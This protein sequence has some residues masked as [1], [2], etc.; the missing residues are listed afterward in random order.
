MLFFPK[1]SLVFVPS[2]SRS[3]IHGLIADHAVV[4]LTITDVVV[5]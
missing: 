1:I 2:D 3:T 4:I 5:G